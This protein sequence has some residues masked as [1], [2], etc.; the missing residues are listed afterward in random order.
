[1]TTTITPDM[2]MERILEI[3][4]AAQRA[5][6]Q[7]YHI[8]GCSSCGFQP[9]D[10]LAQVCKDHNIL[11]VKEVL[12]TIARA[13]DVDT[14]IQVEPK[15]VKQWLDAKEDFSFIDVRTPEELAL[16]RIAGAEPLDYDNPAKY[17]DLPKDRK[18]VFTC[19]SGVRSLDVASYFIG[20]GFQ[21][22]YSMRGGILAWGDE[23]DA[24][25]P[26]Y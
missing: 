24:S 25:V 1:M 2:T 5:L 21:R 10:T 16:A 9:T 18:I 17:M 13:Q 20:H 23:V 19:R 3:A 22:V 14:K 8:G 12:A 26:R 7:R 15:D 4:P 11:D 6:F